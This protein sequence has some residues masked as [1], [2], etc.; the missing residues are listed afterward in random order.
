MSERGTI[1]VV[2]DEE[3]V[4]ESL[5]ALL[6]RKEYRVQTAASASEAL[7]PESLD[8]VEAVITDLKMPGMSGLDLVRELGDRRP[9]LPVIVLTAHGTVE[10]AVESMRAGAFDYVLKPARPEE[11]LLLLD[12]ALTREGERRELAYL[13]DETRERDRP[14]GRSE[15]W[16]RV[17]ELVELAAPVDTSILLQGESGVGKEEVAKLVHARSPR[18]RGPF[19]RVNCAAIPSELVESEFFGHRKGAFTG[20]V[21]DREGRFKVAHRGT[22]LLDEVNSLP[23]GAQAKILRVLQDGE[24]ERVGESKPTRVDVRILCATNADLE[25][26]VEAGRFRADLYYRINV[27]T[28]RIP[29]LRER[30]DDIPLLAETFLREMAP[31]LGRPV[32]EIASDTMARLRSYDWP[33]NVRELRNVIERGIVLTQGDRL[34]PEAL[35]PEIRGGSRGGSEDGAGE[36]GEESLALRETLLRVER[37]LLEEALDRADGV[38]REA[39]KLLEIDERNIAYYLKKHGLHRQGEDA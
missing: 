37:E 18:S 20:A 24:F 2:D 31:R 32:S 35:P 28:I 27:L 7:E 12:R 15:A 21:D 19:V 25:S 14:V 16:K 3:Y 38:R 10:S 17:L 4:R 26:E 22:L 33:G 6:S 11:L 34:L 36:D 9:R 13:R 29:P 30:R 39:A 8:G 5:A 1:L 23:P